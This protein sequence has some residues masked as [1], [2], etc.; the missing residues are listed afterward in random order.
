MR[1]NR[2]WEGQRIILP[3]MRE[4]AIRRCADC[5]FLIK[6]QGREEVRWGCVVGL[7]GYGT[8]EKSVPETLYA[9]EVMKSAGKE[10][11]LKVL[12]RGNPNAQACGH[13]LPRCKKTAAVFQRAAGPT[14]W[15]SSGAR[16][17][18]PITRAWS[19]R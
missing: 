18:P 11:L 17:L 9:V 16:P 15:E 1:D 6:I 2:L 4:R 12:S 19:R 10:G 8:L 5:R 14:C 3:E 13:F 7:P